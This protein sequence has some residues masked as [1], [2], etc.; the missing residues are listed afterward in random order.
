M[1]DFGVAELRYQAGT[2]K[3]DGEWKF[4]R[5][6]FAPVYMTPSAA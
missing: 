4:T 5:R 6:I 2:Q 1:R 3:I